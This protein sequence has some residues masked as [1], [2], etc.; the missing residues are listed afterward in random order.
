MKL[1][2]VDARLRLVYGLGSASIRTFVPLFIVIH[3]GS[4][5]S[6]V[7]TAMIGAMAVISVT[8]RAVS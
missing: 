5:R 6:R 2:A 7:F 1:T 8:G 4:S 3:I